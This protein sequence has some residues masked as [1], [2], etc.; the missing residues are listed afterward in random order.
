[1]YFLETRT[2]IESELQYMS[3]QYILEFIL[4]D[5]YFNSDNSVSFAKILT[6]MYLYAISMI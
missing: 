6:I 3:D 5:I 1:M 2:Q 4:T